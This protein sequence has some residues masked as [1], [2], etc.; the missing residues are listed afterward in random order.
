MQP[1]K[2][3]ALVSLA[4]VFQVVAGG[5]GP[6]LGSDTGGLAQPLKLLALV[7]LAIV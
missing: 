6:A 1:R 4:L 7:S 3:L 2:L 5:C